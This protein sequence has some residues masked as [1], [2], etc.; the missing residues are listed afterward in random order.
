MN[1]SDCFVLTCENGIF[2]NRVNGHPLTELEG[3]GLKTMKLVDNTWLYNYVK[4]LSEIG[5][6]AAQKANKAAGISSDPLMPSPNTGR[7]KIKN[8][9]NELGKE[10]K[11]ARSGGPFE[12]DGQGGSAIPP[13]AKTRLHNV[14]RLRSSLRPSEFTPQTAH[15][16]T[17]KSK[18]KRNIADSYQP[19]RYGNSCAMWDH[20]A[21]VTFPPLP[22]P[23]LVVDLAI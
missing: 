23:K 18:G 6:L 11:L 2:V 3:K 10:K 7:V 1:L 22:Q 17:G 16:C 15:Q 13:T 8:G 20:P 9:R 12:H 19:H 21:A 4:T 14:T 5:L